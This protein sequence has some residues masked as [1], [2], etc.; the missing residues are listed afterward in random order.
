MEENRKAKGR[1]EKERDVEE[2]KIVRREIKNGRNSG[3]KLK[4]AV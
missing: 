1:G 3:K 2:K 4:A